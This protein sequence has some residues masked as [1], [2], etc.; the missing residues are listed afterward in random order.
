M[1]E[2]P[3]STDE[4]TTSDMDESPPKKVKDETDEVA[5][6][7]EEISAPPLDKK[8]INQ[9]DEEEVSASGVDKVTTNEVANS[10]DNA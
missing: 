9:D 4:V 5:G 8:E 3:T 10:I 7:S 2:N 6:F 1:D